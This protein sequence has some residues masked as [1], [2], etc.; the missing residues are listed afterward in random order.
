M[1]LRFLT[2]LTILF[3][4][5]WSTSCRKDFEYAPSNGHLSFSKD[6]V[7]LDTVFSNI[8]SSTY[9]LKVYN[10]TKDD[11]II[12][13]ITLKKGDKSFYRLNVDGVAG[14]EF[15]NIPLYAKD[16]L[17][18]LVETTIEI[19]DNTLNE[20]LYTDAIQ[21]DSEPYQQLVELVTLA[22]D[23]IFL[24]PDVASENSNQ[25][26]VLYNN[27]SGTPIE[28]KGFKLKEE[29]LNFT[30]AKSYVIYGYA[31]VPQEKELVIDAGA[32][33]HFHQNSGI[34]VQD[35][36]QISINGQLSENG[37]LLEG[38][39]IFEGDRLEPEF[40]EIPGQWGAIWISAGSQNNTINHLTLKN[41]ELGIFV[42][43][44]PNTT[45]K[46][47]TISNSRVFNS[48]RY[49]LWAR[50]ASIDATNLILGASGNSSLLIE[51][52]GS[53]SFTHATIANYWNKGFRFNAALE[54]YNSRKN[55]SEDGFDL[56]KAEFKNCIIDGNSST[57]I[58]L[59][60]NNQNSFNFSF[61]NS[62]IKFNEATINDNLLYNFDNEMLFS[63]II[64]DG[65]I[66][67][68]L[69]FENDFRIGLESEVINKGDVNTANSV[70]FD[71]LGEPRLP[72]P[73]LG[74]FQAKEKEM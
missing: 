10:D 70:P 55:A 23:A 59:Q 71:I 34:L 31:I 7:Y 62:F 40:A 28:V 74:A 2:V 39:V 35:G 69:P 8:G 13:T 29:E 33:I 49:N 43:G 12:P 4:I 21:F 42:E 60:S 46:S 32:R 22:K 68:Y 5:L 73:D 66:D 24:F 57:E 30:N 9:T 27:E 20:L 56:T 38:E 15:E 58:L 11:I 48:S 36:A 47:L 26:V 41:A 19:N 17:F 63:T 54:I 53:Y 65:N 45:E 44:K 1:R 64:L 3:I 61:Q 50:N 14:K 37:D 52:G 67:Y 16:S 25:P 72:N 51:N 6:T 18:I